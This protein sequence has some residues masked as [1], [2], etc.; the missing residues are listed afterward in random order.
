MSISG[1]EVITGTNSVGAGP[2]CVISAPSGKVVLGG[3]GWAHM[4]HSSTSTDGDPDLPLIASYPYATD[5]WYLKFAAPAGAWTAGEVI[6]HYA[7]V[8]AD[9]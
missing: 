6:I 8:C 2:A 4:K 1:H 3:G 7:V 5:K 9:A